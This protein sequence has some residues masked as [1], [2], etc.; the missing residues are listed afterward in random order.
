VVDFNRPLAGKTLNF[1]V[2]ITDIKATSVQ[3]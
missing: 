1:N 2:K 3:K